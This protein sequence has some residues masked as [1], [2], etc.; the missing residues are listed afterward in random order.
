MGLILPCAPQFS[1]YE[2]NI[3]ATPTQDPGTTV[4]H[5]TVAHTKNPTFTELI[6]ATAFETQLIVLTLNS[7]NVAAGDSSSLMDIA[8]GAA[9]AESV[10]IPD[11]MA[12]FMGQG[13]APLRHY[14]FPLRIPAGSR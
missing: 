3:T 8:I 12:G 9:A 13:S 4:N 14:I 10:I 5:H 11:L 2:S 7:N 6:A 1:L